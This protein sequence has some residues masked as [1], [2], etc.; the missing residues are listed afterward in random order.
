MK[1]EANER[2]HDRCPE[3]ERRKSSGKVDSQSEERDCGA[4]TMK[5]TGD[6]RG[7]DEA[8]RQ[9][10]DDSRLLLIVTRTLAQRP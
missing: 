6:R 10:Q 1:N 9:R 7:A 8:Q 5:D 2:Q 3:E 4:H